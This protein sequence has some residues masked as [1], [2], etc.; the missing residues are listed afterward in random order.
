MNSKT[1]RPLLAHGEATLPTLSVDSYNLEIED[2]DG[3]LGDRACKSAFWAILD[4]W[5]EVFAE[6][7]K[8]PLGRKS[9][10]VLGKTRLASTLAEGEF[11]AA[12]LVQTAVEEFAVE[13]S[14]ITRRFLRT[15]EWRGTECLVIGGGFRGS[16]L[17]ELAAGR[18]AVILKNEG[19]DIDLK[20]IDNSPD[21][22]G[23]I[24][25]AN[26]LPGWMLKGHTAMLAV[27]IGGTNIRAG[28]VTLKF[29]KSGALREP[30]VAAAELWR[31]ADDDI[32]R[33][34]AAGR[35]VRMLKKLVSEAKDRKLKLAPAIGIG[36]PGLIE[37]DGS[38]SRGAQNLPGNWEA[39]NFNLPQR[40]CE[41]LPSIGG[42][43][44]IVI[45]HNDPVVQ[46]LSELPRMADYARWGVFTIGTGL[47]NARFTNREAG[48]RRRQK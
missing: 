12:A 34:E 21:E 30:A 39:A 19:I 47:G 8:D 14:A 42:H 48:P 31:H 44:T 20:L 1:R 18:S 23:L 35:L 6:E 28:I 9:S 33:D 16:R 4:K 17:G 24:G 36:C 38:I 46:G 45:M 25:A 40:I 15:S 5:R 7:G 43:E 10:E 13:L 11:Q 26:L 27:D 29:K 32:T 22:A 3:F 37:P 2:E 41:E